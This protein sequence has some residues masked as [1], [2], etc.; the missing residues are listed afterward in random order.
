MGKRIEHDSIGKMEVPQSAYYGVQSL[1]AYKNF[2]ITG[3][4]LNSKFIVSLAEIKKAAA[5]T[6]YNSQNLDFILTGIPVVTLALNCGVLSKSQLEQVL[7][8][9]AMTGCLR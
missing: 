1:W 2:H 4:A 9:A 8:P 7:D 6:N 3:R 5:I